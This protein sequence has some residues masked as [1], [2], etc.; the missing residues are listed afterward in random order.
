LTAEAASRG[1]GVY[2]NNLDRDGAEQV[3]AAYGKNDDRLIE[4]KYK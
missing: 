1:G 2:T 3:R 4:L